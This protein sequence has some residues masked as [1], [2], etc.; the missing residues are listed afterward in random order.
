[1]RRREILT[2]PGLH[3][4]PA[5]RDLSDLALRSVLHRCPAVRCL[6]L[7]PC[8]F[9]AASSVPAS[10]DR[11]PAPP[12]RAPLPAT[13]R[14]FLPHS[15]DRLWRRCDRTPVL[16]RATDSPRCCCSRHCLL[17]ASDR[18]RQCLQPA[19]STSRTTPILLCSLFPV[20]VFCLTLPNHLP[21][22]L[23]PPA[24]RLPAPY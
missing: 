23:L 20:P 5:S 7:R 6:P 21:L 14:L 24:S 9:V 3:L 19:S 10:T 2:N 15:A 1:M 22:C 11:E 12:P 16:P 4:C 18:D 8:Y 17:C 13:G